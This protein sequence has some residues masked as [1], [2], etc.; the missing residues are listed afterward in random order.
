LKVIQSDGVLHLRADTSNAIVPEY[1]TNGN[2]PFV[3]YSVLRRLIFGTVSESIREESGQGDPSVQPL[4][5][6]FLAQLWTN[7]R[8]HSHTFVELGH[9]DIGLR[10]QGEAD[11]LAPHN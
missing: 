6:D 8:A 4:E 3:R 11:R 10:L 7:L 9:I 1:L 5:L 2:I